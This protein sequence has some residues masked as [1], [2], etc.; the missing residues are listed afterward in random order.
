MTD[1]A[2]AQLEKLLKKFKVR[3][4]RSAVRGTHGCNLAASASDSS[5]ARRIECVQDTA[6]SEAQSEAE[7]E[8]HRDVEAGGDQGALH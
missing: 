3:C 8:P 4:Q 6:E 2:V 7:Y 1:N 5:L